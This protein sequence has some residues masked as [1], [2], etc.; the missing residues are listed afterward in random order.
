MTSAEQLILR[1]FTLGDESSALA[2]Q[3][4]LQEDGFDFLLEVTPER[5][6]AE[7][8]A[9]LH[10]V[11]QGVNLAQDRVQAELL[12][13]DVGGELVGRTSIRHTI[14]HPFLNEYGGHIG[15][16]V[17]PQFRRRGY[18]TAILRL[19]LARA[20]ELGIEQ[21]LVTCDDDNARSAATIENCGGVFERMVTFEG[22]PRRRYWV[23]TS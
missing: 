3:A 9:R 13:A 10:E 17:R 5:T 21:A 1:P 4:E 15:Y 22:V 14:D 19:S 23:P 6:W 7:C 8:V 2:A 18:A 20:H 11:G 12:A 16:A